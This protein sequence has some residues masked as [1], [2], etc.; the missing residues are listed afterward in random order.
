MVY[1]WRAVNFNWLNERT[2][3]NDI[4]SGDVS[5]GK[6]WEYAHK[7]SRSAINSL[8]R[9]LLFLFTF[10]DYPELNIPNT[11]NMIEGIHSDLKRRLAN[12]R[13]LKKNRKLSSSEFSSLEEQRCKNPHFYLLL[14]FLTM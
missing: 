13:G 8:F 7:E 6:R 12:H 14:I 5:N 3:Y 2:C 1:V 10:E 9:N 11:N 4:S